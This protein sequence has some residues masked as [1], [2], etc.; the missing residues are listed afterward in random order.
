MTVN[1]LVY[2]LVMINPFAQVLYVWELLHRLRRRELRRP[3]GA[4]RS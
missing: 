2:M 4:P 1:L 3:T